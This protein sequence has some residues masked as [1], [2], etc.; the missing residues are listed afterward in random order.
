MHPTH[1]PMGGQANIDPPPS[2]PSFFFFFSFSTRPRQMGINRKSRK[3]LENKLVVKC[4]RLNFYF[5]RNFWNR[6]RDRGTSCENFEARALWMWSSKLRWRVRGRMLA[7]QIEDKRSKTP[8][9]NGTNKCCAVNTSWHLYKEAKPCS[10]WLLLTTLWTKACQ[11]GLRLV[12]WL[13]G[14]ENNNSKHSTRYA[15]SVFFLVLWLESVQ[16]SCITAW[17]LPALLKACSNVNNSNW[18]TQPLT[19]KPM[20]LLKLLIY[21]SIEKCVFQEA[22][23]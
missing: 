15:S 8:E 23:G 10:T 6:E 7:A 9:M 12:S 1:P 14:Q 18:L 21:L 22:A 4:S 17:N 2:S 16:S 13:F 3:P 11:W 20:G 19:S 5:K